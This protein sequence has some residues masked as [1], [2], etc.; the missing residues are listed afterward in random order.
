M[1]IEILIIEDNLKVAKAHQLYVEKVPGFSVTGVVNLLSNAL[2]MVEALEPDLILLDIYFPD[3][4]GMDLLEQLRSSHS[5]C[6]VILITAAK[7]VKLLHNALRGGVFDYMIKPVFF[8]RFEEALLNYRKHW[9]NLN[10]IENMDQ[11][12]IDQFFQ[13]SS[14]SALGNN[15]QDLPKGIDPLTLEKVLAIFDESPDKGISAE[16]VG[17]IIGASRTTARK[18]LEYFISTGF[19]KIALEYGTIGRPERRYFKAE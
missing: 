13:R 3:G 11:Q 6:D 7:D 19:L 9:E 10:K 14:Q 12:E 5:N 17:K 8:E 1:D 4:N 16:E 15:D 18:Y 2:Q